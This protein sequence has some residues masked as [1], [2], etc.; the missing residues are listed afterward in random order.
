MQMVSSCNAVL[1]SNS[2]SAS[3]CLRAREFAVIPLGPRTG[4]I[5]WVDKTVPLFSIYHRSQ[6]H[7]AVQASGAMR[8]V[9]RE[10]MLR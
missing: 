3:R 9:S 2:L 6:H 4:L 7:A 1:R 5:E 10:S 8:K